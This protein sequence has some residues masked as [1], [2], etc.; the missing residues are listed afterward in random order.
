VEEDKV[1]EKPIEPSFK[2]LPNDPA[3][4]ERQNLMSQLE[5]KLSKS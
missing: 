2:L 3:M 4:K 1:E 5:E